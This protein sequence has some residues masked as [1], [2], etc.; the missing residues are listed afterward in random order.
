MLTADRVLKLAHDLDSIVENLDISESRYLEAVKRYEAVG[1]WLS[2]EKSPLLKLKFIPRIYS[3]GS[4]RLGTVVR[5]INNKDECDIDLVCLLTAEEQK[6][7]T[8]K[9]LK[10]IVGESLKQNGIYAKLLDKEGR[11]CW[12]LNYEN[13]FHLDILPAILDV[14][15]NKVGGLYKTAIKITD[16]AESVYKWEPSNP[17]GYATW[18]SERQK[19]IFASLKKSMG[20]SLKESI[21][22]VPDYKVRTPLQKSVQVLKRHRDVYF[23]GKENKPASIIITTICAVLYNGQ[24]DVYTALHDILSDFD[25]EQYKKEEGYYLANPSNIAENFMERWNEDDSLP[26]AFFE[27]LEDAKNDFCDTG[28]IRK[29]S[30]DVTTILE[31]KLGTTIKTTRNNLVNSVPLVSINT[32]NVS[33]RQPWGL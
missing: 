10:E 26:L 29:S 23:D 1:S 28:L 4:F 30:A 31:A 5:P 25:I 6:S 14:E 20:A 2:S 8:S 13:E 7:I 9:E 12:T 27:W 19:L 22:E 24:A 3:Q 17:D 15:L 32:G 21:D 18:F 33:K 11:R 16:K